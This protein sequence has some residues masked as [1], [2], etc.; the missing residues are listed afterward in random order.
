MDTATYNRA[1]PVSRTGLY[2]TIGMI[3][4]L[5]VIIYAVNAARTDRTESVVGA[6]QSQSAGTTDTGTGYTETTNGN[7]TNQG[8]GGYSGSGT[9]TNPNPSTGTGTTR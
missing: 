5:A 2:W 4:A 9:N 8:A 6:T 7:N 3:I 1:A